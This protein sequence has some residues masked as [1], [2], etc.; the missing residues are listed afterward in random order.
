[1]MVETEVPRPNAPM[2]I[3]SPQFDAS[4]S[5]DLTGMNT[6]ISDSTSGIALLSRQRE[7]HEREHR[8]RHFRLAVFDA[9]RRII[10][11]DGEHDR[12]Q[13]EDAE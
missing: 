5:P 13:Q 2:A 4:T 8:H 9:L 1:M 7:K 6:G 11:T 10:I 12:Q 3:S